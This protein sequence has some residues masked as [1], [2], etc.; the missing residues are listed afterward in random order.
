MRFL[1]VVDNP[2]NWPLHVPGV[3]VVSSR[4]YLTDPGFNNRKGTRVF[5]LCKSYSYQ[6]TGYYVSLLA[7][8]RG[9]N[10]IPDVVTIQDMKSSSL[11]RVISD[12]LDRMIQKTL[13]PIHTEEF[14]LSIYFGKTLAQRDR[15]LGLRLFGLFRS[16]LLR[17]QFARKADKWQLQSM[18]PI[19]AS[20]ITDA[21]R[22]EVLE[23]A[24]DYFA[25]RQWSGPAAKPPRYD[26]A[27]LIDP[28]E[29]QPPSD[30][31]GL[32][33]F[34]RAAHRLEVGTELITKDDFGSLGEF[35]ALFI[36][37]TTFVDHYTYRFARRAA[38]DGLAVID[39][40]VSIARCTNKVYLAERLSVNKVP[41]PRTVIVDQENQGTVIEQL[42]LPCV[43]KQPDSAFSR[44]VVRVD[45]AEEYQVKVAELLDE[46]DLIIAQ[47]FMPTEFDWR[48]GVLD[49]QPLYV[50]KYFMAR[51]HWQ[52][53]QRS[54]SGKI[55]NGMCETLPWEAAPRKVIST[56]LKAANLIGDGF[57]G[58]DLKQVG[59]DVYVIEVNDNPSIDGGIEDSVVKD[60]LYDRVIESFIQRIERIRA[61][62]VR[63][64]G[65]AGPGPV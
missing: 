20:E 5:N 18:R 48:V 52:I 31:H 54:A 64:G 47:E 55:V 14:T 17:A 33:K 51:N 1:M 30:R 49:G 63:R 24:S 56:A 26:M 12:D 28:D 43:L 6:S 45:T 11:V 50:C 60:R 25:R 27:I 16:P 19:P 21:H 39:D 61:G 34:I 29:E 4:R 65:W 36:R 23:A 13:R 9:H 40:P 8:A 35:D 59:K 7:E 57:Y 2:A 32:E 42:G 22:P 15:Q 44:G 46:S 53:L 58:V 62:I 37:T 38:A 41:I 10:P 3:E